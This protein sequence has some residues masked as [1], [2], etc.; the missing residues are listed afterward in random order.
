MACSFWTI[1]D[2][3]LISPLLISSGIGA[4]RALLVW[5]DP[6]RFKKQKNKNMS[7]EFKPGRTPTGGPL[8]CATCQAYEGLTEKFRLCQGC[9]M[10]RYCSKDCQKADW[11][12]HKIE[13][14]ASSQATRP[15]SSDWHKV[16]ATQRSEALKFLELQLD[17]LKSP[18]NSRLNGFVQLLNQIQVPDPS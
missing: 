14:R 8:R 1:E 5:G 11:K 4:M 2:R 16:S 15:E 17:Y 6:D 7:R 3:A 12:R 18:A 9:F 13:C 10:V